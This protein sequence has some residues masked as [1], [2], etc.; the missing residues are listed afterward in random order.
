MQIRHKPLREQ[1]IVITGASSG[2]GLATARAAARRGARVVLAARNGA[3]LDD[4]VRDIQERGGEARAA[5]T[6]VSRRE[7]VEALAAETVRAYGGF[8]TWVN[9]AGLSIFGRLEEVSDEDHRRLFDVNFWGIVYGSTVA[10]QHLKR[11]GGALINLGSVASDLA[12]PIQG[13]YS[14]SKHAIKGFTD[15][16]RMELQE[17][18]APVSVTLIKPASIDT[19]FPEHARN[20]MAQAPKLPPPVYDPADVADAILYAAEHGP[21]DLYVGGGGKLMSALRKRV[22]AST[23]WMGAQVMSRSQTAGAAGK[24]RDGALHAAGRDGAVRGGSPHHVMRSAYTRASINP[25]LTGILL[26][27]ATAAAASLLGRADRR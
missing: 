6:D 7:D 17:E 15:A 4:I 5:V 14:A 16:L 8:D 26:A 24:R 2:I 19:P 22:P 13:M 10:L 27:G 1:V 11:T 18:G 9:N 20:Y 21:R 3:A 25:V 12:L 23:D